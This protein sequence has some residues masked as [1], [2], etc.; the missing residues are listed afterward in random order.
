MSSINPIN[1]E[2]RS[3]KEN[4]TP[5]SETDPIENIV[6]Q[7][8][9][10]K[11]E[12]SFEVFFNNSKKNWMVSYKQKK[13][14]IT[15][16]LDKKLVDLVNQ[17]HPNA[18]EAVQRTYGLKRGEILSL[19]TP[20][21]ERIPSIDGICIF[22]DMGYTENG[23]VNANT[24]FTGKFSEA[25]K[26]NLP[27][28]VS[29]HLISNALKK[30]YTRID[31]LKDDYQFFYGPNKSYIVLIPTKYT[32]LTL[33]AICFS[34]HLKPIQDSELE[35]NQLDSTFQKA[36]DPK[37][38]D[39]KSIFS[40][41]SD[42][43][44]PILS[45]FLGGHGNQN[46]VI[47]LPDAQYR[48]FVEHLNHVY[49]LSCCLISSCSP[50]GI[51]PKINGILIQL[52]NPHLLVSTAHG[53]NYAKMLSHFN[54]IDMRFLFSTSNLEKLHDGFNCFKMDIRNRPMLWANFFVESGR[55]ILSP[56]TFPLTYVKMKQKSLQSQ[57]ENKP[58]IIIPKRMDELQLFLPDVSSVNLVF[59]K[60][61]M[62]IISH[63]KEQCFHI[64]D[65]VTT[66]NV[67]NIKNLGDFVKV[68]LQHEKIQDY[69]M[70]SFTNQSFLFKK[71]T[72]NDVTYENVFVLIEKNKAPVIK[73]FLKGKEKQFL[74]SVISGLSLSRPSD[75]AIREATGGNQTYSS[76]LSSLQKLFFPGEKWVA[77]LDSPEKL[78][79]FLEKEKSLDPEMLTII[80]NHI[81]D[82]NY[83]FNIPNLKKHLE[84]LASIN[85]WKKYTYENN[86]EFHLSIIDIATHKPTE[87]EELRKLKVFLFFTTPKKREELVN[88]IET[89]APLD[90][91][92]DNLHVELVKLLLKY[93]A[94]SPSQEGYGY[95]LFRIRT[96]DQDSQ[97]LISFIMQEQIKKTGSLPTGD[98]TTLEG[99]KNVL[100]SKATLLKVM[101]LITYTSLLQPFLESLELEINSMLAKG[102]LSTEMEIFI[103]ELLKKACERDDSVFLTRLLSIL[104]DL[105]S[106]GKKINDEKL[107][108]P[109]SNLFEKMRSGELLSLLFK[110]K[111]LSPIQALTK[112]ASTNQLEVLAWILKSSQISTEDWSSFPRPEG[113]AEE[114][115]PDEVRLT[116]FQNLRKEAI[117][118]D[119]LE[120]F[121]VLDN[122]IY[123]E[124]GLDREEQL[125]EQIKLAK[126]KPRILAYLVG[127]WNKMKPRSWDNLRDLIAFDDLG[128]ISL[129][130][131]L[132]INLSCNNKSLFELLNI[133]TTRFL[134]EEAGQFLKKQLEKGLILSDREVEEIAQSDHLETYK[135]LYEKIFQKQLLECPTEEFSKVFIKLINPNETI[136]KLNYL[137][138]CLKEITLRR[139]IKGQDLMDQLFT[140]F[141]QNATRAFITLFRLYLP[142][143]VKG[144]PKN[145]FVLLDRLLAK[146][147]GKEDLETLNSLVKNPLF[148]ILTDKENIMF[149]KA[150]MLTILLSE[151]LKMKIKPNKNQL[152]ELEKLSTITRKSIRLNIEHLLSHIQEL[153]E[154]YQEVDIDLKEE[155]A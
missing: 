151:H 91:A 12:G 98:L 71:V 69:D 150:Q 27:I 121:E 33:S 112:A 129:L 132:D 38:E 126:D 47:D 53:V 141:D 64:F 119:C 88:Q 11:S 105:P 40:P 115:T 77:Y 18:L 97:N 93:D 147:E 127:Q 29:P 106:L 109:F 42:N 37:Y 5:I 2:V 133:L 16:D 116:I 85:F 20:T 57:T 137:N 52:G 68:A 90:L 9:M 60:E 8:L 79:R 48:D 73:V 80:M 83:H 10:E 138:H 87:I 139:Q 125:V 63:V 44:K 46:E 75:K 62:P 61:L 130:K 36:A 102:T 74:E 6:K 23:G 67:P 89:L 24:S 58:E 30:G 143:Y 55:P 107:N 39:L 113:R 19:E 101:N 13:D 81:F 148:S 124:S 128:S 70:R 54:S 82:N 56:R 117:T 76:M 118:Q 135:V 95:A 1:S 21:P 4:S 140:L 86:K 120:L 7:I 142:L 114:A 100:F 45:F 123:Q 108:Y 152:I 51:Q 78:E 153:P 49:T 144:Q 15:K 31:Q 134:L 28:V 26:Q 94:V 50:H 104:P 14:V 154:A 99:P 25:S 34:S 136:A 72:I 110:K 17:R 84:R 65:T 92:I 155:V 41:S 103:D 32:D 3:E 122:S 96:W 35:T 22:N 59:E 146:F 145:L 66:N 149:I 43:K 131:L 111:W